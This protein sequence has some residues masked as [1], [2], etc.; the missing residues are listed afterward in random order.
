[1]ALPKVDFQCP[2]T[3][4]FESLGPPEQ[5]MALDPGP[6][7]GGVFASVENSLPETLGRDSYGIGANFNSVLGAGELIYVRAFGHPATGDDAGYSATIRRTGRS[8]SARSCRFQRRTA[9]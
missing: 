3:T 7:L 4:D 9:C 6:R 5:Q 8:P 1:M 2:N